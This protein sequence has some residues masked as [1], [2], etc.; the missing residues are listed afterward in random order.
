METK[1]K[2]I[3][4]RKSVNHTG[5]PSLAKHTSALHNKTVS[6]GPRAGNPKSFVEFLETEGLDTDRFALEIYRQ[7]GKSERDF[8]TWSAKH[9]STSRGRFW[10]EQFNKLIKRS[11][12]RA[13][14][15]AKEKRPE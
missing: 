3:A 5:A 10:R 14:K 15:R 12:K 1:R 4:P 8:Q 2:K 6:R 9:G 13:I 11:I 7:S